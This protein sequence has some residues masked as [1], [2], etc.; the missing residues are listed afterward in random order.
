MEF[1]NELLSNQPLIA[2]F[3]AWFV[4]QFLKIIIKVVKKNKIDFKLFVSPGG[5]P[6]SHAAAVA[7]LATSSGLN[8]GFDSGLFAISFVI[9]GLVFFDAKVVRKEAGK[10]AEALN[11]IIENLYKRQGLKIEHLK[12]LLGHT[13]LEIFF[14]IILGILVG[15]LLFYCTSL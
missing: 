5:F 1:F 11:K 3:I 2:T 13:S 9:L 14:G 8:F 15:S 4:S 6:S 10:Q 7:A 12:E